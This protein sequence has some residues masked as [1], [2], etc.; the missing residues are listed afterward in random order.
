[1]N[2]RDDSGSKSAFFVPQA[3]ILNL[4]YIYSMRCAGDPH[5]PLILSPDMYPN[6]Y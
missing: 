2:K 6:S 4:K 1:M 5:K 3:T